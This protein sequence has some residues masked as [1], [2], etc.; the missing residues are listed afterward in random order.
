MDQNQTYLHDSDLITWDQEALLRRV[1]GRPALVQKLV[2]LFLRDMPE[3][4][5]TL[6]EKIH[7]AAMQEIHQIAHAIKGVSANLSI[8]RVQELAQALEQAANREE[9]DQINSLFTQLVIEYQESLIP[10]KK[11]LQQA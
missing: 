8:L 5:E 11:C 9:L 7:S 3:R 10:L 4:I 1:R 6:E 2:G